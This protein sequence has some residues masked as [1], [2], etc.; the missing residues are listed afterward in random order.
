M[1]CQCLDET[2]MNDQFQK[3]S[4]KG[5]N[6]ACLRIIT[7]GEVPEELCVEAVVRECDDARQ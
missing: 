4:F 5:K 6:G 1:N 3:I 7:R 2:T